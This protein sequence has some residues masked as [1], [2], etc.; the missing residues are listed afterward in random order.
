MTSWEIM[1]GS[2]P[3]YVMVM[4][5]MLG[6]LVFN[7]VFARKNMPSV[8][9]IALCL[10]IT[11]AVAPGLPAMNMADYQAVDW[12]VEMGKQFIF[13]FFLGFVFVI[14]YNMIS[15]IGD[16]IDFEMGLSMAKVFDPG[17]GIQ[18]SVTGRMF[19][20]IFA[21]YFFTTNSHL[22]LIKLFAR[23]FELLPIGGDIQIMSAA[24]YLIDLFI[25]AFSLVLRLGL[26]FIAA[27]FVLEVS[28]G[29]LMKLIPQ[30]HVFVINIQLKLI[31]GIGMMILFAAPITGFLDQFLNEAL[32]ST[33]EAL[34]LLAG[35]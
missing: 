30:I 22:L 19:E 17:T 14:F 6:L 4:L 2:L 31:L 34:A 25:S 7:P 9:R 8:V 23:S 1:L 5:R 12:L 20:I 24:G 3:V 27:E 32:V 11:L 15:Y 35:R 16:I 10:V 21:L 13:G 28:M 18:S 33:Q 29:V 26:P